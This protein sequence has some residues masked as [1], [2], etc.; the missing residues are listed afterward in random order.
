MNTFILVLTL[1]KNAKVIIKNLG[2]SN[3][4]QISAMKRMYVKRQR[5]SY[6]KIAL[7]NYK[8]LGEQIMNDPNKKVHDSEE[9]S[10]WNFLHISKIDRVLDKNISQRPF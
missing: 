1:I 9:L 3:F 5:N 2:L 10:F 7:V 6:R 4:N 8:Q